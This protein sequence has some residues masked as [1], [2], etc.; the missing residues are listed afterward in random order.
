M[1]AAFTIGAMTGAMVGLLVAALAASASDRDDWR[2]E[3]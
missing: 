3:D 1:I 2:E